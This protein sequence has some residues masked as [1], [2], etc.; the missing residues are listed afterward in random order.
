MKKCLAIIAVFWAVAVTVHAAPERP[1]RFAELLRQNGYSDM[2]VAYLESLAARSDLPAEV[3]DL[4]DLEMAK[5][6]M[7]AAG[8]AFDARDKEELLRRSR[9]HLAKFVRE[10]SDHPA[11]P[12]A[13]AA[14][15]DFLLKEAIEKIRQSKAT[16]DKEQQERDIADARAA[17]AGAREKFEQAEEKFRVRLEELSTP[18]AVP[19]P[20]KTERDERLEVQAQALALWREAQFQVA[21]VKY[22]D[23]QTYLDAKSEEHRK[24]LE[25]AAKAFDDVFQQDRSSMVGLTDAGLK[26]HLWH[27]RTAQ[28]L[29]KM[30]LALDIYD[31]VLAGAPD[32]N[33]KK[34][35]DGSEAFFAQVEFYRL[36]VLARRKPIEFLAE[37]NAWMQH[38]RHLRE[39]EGYQAIALETAR[40]ILSLA[41]GATGAERSRRIL[42]ARRILADMSKVRSPYQR[43]AILLRRE[44]LGKTG[45]ADLDVKTFDDAVALGDV[46]AADGQWEQAQ[47]AYEKAIEIAERTKRADA[48]TLGNIREALAGVRCMIARDLFLAGKYNEC[49]DRAGQLVYDEGPD[50]TVR[51]DSPAAAEAAA[52]AVA[53]AL[54]LY[55]EA[56]DDQKP[57]ALD[58]LSKLAEF[59]ETN[60]PDRPE[61]DDARMARGQAKL[62]TGQTREA[63][64]IFERVNP[65]SARYGLA[66]C[67]AG[68]NYWRLYVAEKR[69]PE[70]KQDAGRMAADRAKAVERLDTGVRVLHRES[71]AGRPPSKTLVA[72]QSL[73]AR[74]RLE[75]DDPA[76]A[77]ALYEPLVDWIE[78]EKPETLDDESLGVF[79]G[80]VHAYGAVGEVDKAGRV[81]LLLARLGPDTPRV[82]AVLV[83][84]AWFLGEEYKKAQDTVA[85]LEHTLSAAKLEKAKARLKSIQATLRQLLTQL[86]G[87]QKLSPA[88]MVFVGDTLGALGM[89]A[90]A[91]R[92]YQKILR[93][94][95]SDPEFAK[96]AQQAM[97][98]VRAQLAGLLRQEGKHEE[99]LKQVDRLIADYPRALEPLMEKGKILQDWSAK[100]PERYGEAVAHWVSLRTRLQS[101][102][103]KPPEYY[104]VMYNVAVCLIRQAETMKDKTG[105]LARALEAEQVLK[106]ALILNPKLNGPETV[107]RYKALLSQ[108][109]ALQGRKPD[110]KKP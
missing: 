100:D 45:G 42:D 103:K 5:S 75:G 22:Y 89:N 78:S 2:A 44:V 96:T 34:V 102:R 76:G 93:R 32:P 15:G 60:W 16:D 87:R 72:A 88:G 21:L 110:A 77:A 51:R 40:S 58:K 65:K 41:E 92:Q 48:D 49:I 109:L 17:L 35:S 46:A 9:E 101:L 29:G 59:T 38:H 91:S 23:A 74:I 107:A 71:G 13:S 69:K 84:C 19:S 47:T 54:N 30:Q 64:D 20:K 27:G 73:L 53:A 79:L 3:R 61:A 99:A 90:E 11:A 25:R 68:Q 7:T 39:T 8:D 97:T 55:A 80:A 70:G 67:L 104:D 14:W 98:R 66:L 56:P 57:A 12:M 31:E 43:E 10:K 63:I 6:L 24:A 106:S 33:D 85:E 37:A 1:L 81:G 36:M 52:L 86:S 94:A 50:R 4:L 62:V 26:A 95:E 18:P 83:Q 82:D 108:A 105:A 28:E